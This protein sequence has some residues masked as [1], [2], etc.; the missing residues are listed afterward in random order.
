MVRP[1][2]ITG[3]FGPRDLQRS[4]QRLLQLKAARPAAASRKR[5][6]HG[7]RFSAPALSGAGVVPW[8]SVGWLAGSD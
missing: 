2:A 4:F 3:D 8:D 7:I 6:C 5:R 1:A